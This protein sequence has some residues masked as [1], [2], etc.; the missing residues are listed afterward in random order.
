[1]QH[2]AT[3]LHAEQHT[4]HSL[5]AR[6]YRK[7]KNTLP[8]HHEHQHEHEHASS[9]A[10]DEEASTT[11]HAYSR[12]SFAS[13]ELA[14][15]RVA[16]LLPEE[17]HAL[18]PSPFPHAPA[19]P[20]KPYL[21]PA[22]VQKELAGPPSR[23]YTLTNTTSKTHHLS[24][25]TETANLRKTHLNVLSTLLHRCLLQAD[26]DRAGRAWGLILRTQVAGGNPV[27][28]RNHGRWAIG[29][30]ILLRRTPP[31]TQTHQHANTD[32]DA[33][34]NTDLFSEA[35]FE[36]AR[37]YYERLIV[38]FPT[39]RQ[40]PH[41]VDQRS[42]YPAMFSLW[43]QEVCAKSTRT[44]KQLQEARSRRSS[45]LDPS[46]VDEQ[47]HDQQ[48]RN[49]QDR[50]DAIQ[51]SELTSAM[52]I[53]ERLDALV[54]SPPFD[55]HASLLQ[56][57]GNLSL[58]ISDLI[59]ANATDT[60]RDEWDVYP[61]NPRLSPA[62]Q[63]KRFSTCERELRTARN[64]LERVDENGGMRQ[65]AVLKGIDARIKEL[66]RQMGVLSATEGEGH[67][68]GDVDMEDVWY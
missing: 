46:P 66:Q 8:D 31:T 24:S 51:V 54:T 40:A 22:T 14:Q 36:L 7:R 47:D 42:F 17:E 38:Q 1:M 37:E 6:Q 57:R 44:R 62:E 49:Q 50:E 33:N 67:G 34:T 29:A 16:G 59:V 53:A 21:A 52:E 43:I 3:Q 20:S 15:L 9:S 2:F 48:D 28:L 11:P 18:P 63:A 10:S 39:R 12:P 68:S 19:T 30:E 26:Y 61:M 41:A 64:Y 32:T 58:W 13:P 4:T 5:R 27:D 55:K 35:G 56:L 23:L 45:S 25:H 60:L 65:F